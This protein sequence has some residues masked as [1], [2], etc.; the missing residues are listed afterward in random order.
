MAGS[1]LLPEHLADVA[2]VRGA[3][4][5]HLPESTLP[6]GVLLLEDV[7]QERLAAADL[8]G[9][10]DVE[11][12]LRTAVRL[13]LR[14]GYDS[15]CSTSVSIG[16]S[17]VSMTGSAGASSPAAFAAALAASACARLSGASTIVMLRPSRRGDASTLARCLV[18]SA[19]PSR[20]F[21]PSSGWATSRPRNM[22]VSFTLWPSARKCSTFLVLVSKS[23]LPI[24]TRY[25]ISLMEIWVVLRRDSF[26]FWAASYLNLP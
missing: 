15:V 8:A 10:R 2:R 23:P 6:V 3:D 13:H 12:L 19:T 16:G 7:V 24:L 25:F 22:I 11:P 17:S 14:H 9:A 21:I 4:G 26:C 18:A 20:I 5:G 1:P